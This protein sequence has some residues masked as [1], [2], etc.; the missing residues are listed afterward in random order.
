MRAADR[1]NGESTWTP[2]ALKKNCLLP[3]SLSR[4]DRQL[5]AMV[6]LFKVSEG[7]RSWETSQSMNAEMCYDGQG[8][9]ISMLG[10]AVG[11]ARR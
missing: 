6:T 5:V 3:R 9:I 11:F 4:A 7:L 2:P 1:S 10:D 8:D